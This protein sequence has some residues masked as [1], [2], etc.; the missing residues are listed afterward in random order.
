MKVKPLAVILQPSLKI[1]KHFGSVNIHPMS[2][3]VV[4][5]ENARFSYIY[6]GIP[7]TNKLK[8]HFLVCSHFFIIKSMKIT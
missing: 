1:L 6:K 3:E 7:F 5:F 4:F 8:T 2:R